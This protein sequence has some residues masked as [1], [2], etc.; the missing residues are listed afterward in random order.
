[1][2]VDVGVS[3]GLQPVPCQDSA[4]GLPARRSAAGRRER[5]DRRPVQQGE[6]GSHYSAADRQSASAERGGQE[7]AKKRLSAAEGKLREIQGSNAPSRPAS[8]RRGGGVFAPAAFRRAGNPV[9]VEAVRDCRS[10]RPSRYSA[11]IRCTTSTGEIESP[12][13]R[14]TVFEW[15]ACRKRGRGTCLR[16]SRELRA[17]V[18]ARSHSHLAHLSPSRREPARFK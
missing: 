5:L 18:L 10:P 13:G 16:S 2:Q 7:Q 12:S 1:M 15:P 8:R 3:A 17:V 11:K 6:R 14:C 4:H 9:A